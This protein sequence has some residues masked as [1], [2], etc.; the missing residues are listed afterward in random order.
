MHWQH[1]V[2]ASSKYMLI[3]KWDTQIINIH[4]FIKF[5]EENIQW[6]KPMMFSSGWLMMIKF[7]WNTCHQ[8]KMDSPVLG[9][10]CHK[11][12]HLTKS[13]V[14]MVG[15]QLLHMPFELCMK[16]HECCGISNYQ[17]LNWFFNSMF[18]FATRKSKL[19]I[20]MAIHWWCTACI[21]LE[22]S[23]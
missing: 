10:P 1:S 15:D 16:S 14:G 6:H 18:M 22:R 5:C 21:P 20:V 7:F 17:Q 3:S 13:R 19:C 11:P 9:R 12:V 23:V 8:I 2:N 4:I